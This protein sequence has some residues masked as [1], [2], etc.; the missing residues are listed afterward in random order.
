VHFLK[1][2]D[3]EVPSFTTRAPSNRIRR[4][5]AARATQGEICHQDGAIVAMESHSRWFD[6]YQGFERRAVAL[7][8][9]QSTGAPDRPTQAMPI[10]ARRQVGQPSSDLA[11]CPSLAHDDCTTLIHADDV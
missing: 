8:K 7:G 11:A 9:P 10:E 5:C 3:Y 6:D 2:A 1:I 4:L